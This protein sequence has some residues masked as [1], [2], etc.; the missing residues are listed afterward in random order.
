MEGLNSLQQ[1]SNS[2]ELVGPHSRPYSHSREL[3]GSRGGQDGSHGRPYPHPR[4]QYGARGGQDGSHGRPYPHPREQYGSRGGQDGPH[5][6]PYPHPREQYGARG[7]QDGSHGRHDFRFREPSSSRGGQDG[8]HGRPYPHPRERDGSCE[9]DDGSHS[10]A[11]FRSLKQYDAPKFD[12]RNAIGGSAQKSQCHSDGHSNSL[13]GLIISM[14][15]QL[16]ISGCQSVSFNDILQRLK[17]TTPT[18]FNDVCK[19]L[20]INQQRLEDSLKNVGLSQLPDMSWSAPSHLPPVE[21]FI[22]MVI[23]AFSNSVYRFWDAMKCVDN[24]RHAFK[25]DKN[26]LITAAGALF[27]SDVHGFL[28]QSVLNAKGVRILSDLGGKVDEKDTSLVETIKRETD[29]ETNSML[30]DHDIKSSI[31]GVCHNP[32]CKYLLVVCQAPESFDR[33]DLASFGSI[34]KHSSIPRTLLWVSISDFI[35]SDTLHPRLTC[36]PI[37]KKLIGQLFPQ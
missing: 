19:F 9:R 8:S 15:Y 6:R 11:D 25:T 21:Q 34:E 36:S 23:G 30:P 33:M 37:V 12:H 2:T 32:Q 31:M 3:D 27:Y 22:P 16:F 35:E 18:A 17:E 13:L 28:M 7:G 20:L 26:I 29:E 5:S 4:E 24:Q 10:R 14:V 1:H